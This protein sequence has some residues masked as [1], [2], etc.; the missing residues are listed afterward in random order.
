LTAIY[1]SGPNIFF[2]RVLKLIG[3]QAGE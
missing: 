1:H 2:K 3:S